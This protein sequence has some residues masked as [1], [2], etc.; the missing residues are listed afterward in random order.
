LISI[1]D[2]TDAELYAKAMDRLS[3]YSETT[4]GYVKAALANHEQAPFIQ[5]FYH[6]YRE[7]V[8]GKECQVWVDFGGKFYC[9]E[10]KVDFSDWKQSKLLTFDHSFKQKL[11]ER[12]AILYAN[13]QHETFEPMLKILKSAAKKHDDFNFVLRF[14]PAAEQRRAI[15]LSGY[16]VE[17]DVKNTEYKAVDDRKVTNEDDQDSI[18]SKETDAK[19]LLYEPEPSIQKLT[20]EQISEI[21]GRAITFASESEN[22]WDS[23]VQLTQ[24]FPKYAHLLLE[25]SVNSDISRESLEM[26]QLA[27]GEEQYLFMNGLNID[28]EDINVF[29]MLRMMR[30]DTK[31]IKE[32]ESVGFS[33]SEAIDLISSPMESKSDIEWGACFNVKTDLA[34]WL[35]D[36]EK[37]AMYAQ[38][39]S[40]L[41]TLMYPSHGNQF[42]FIR[43]NLFSALFVVDLTNPSVLMELPRLYQIIGQ[44]VPIRFGILPYIGVGESDGVSNLVAIAL[45]YI[46]KNVPGQLNSFL[47]QVSFVDVDGCRYRR[48]SSETRHYPSSI[49]KSNWKAT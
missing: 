22:K 49:S 42:K 35:N 37:D 38:F 10:F 13:I 23:L 11:T 18:T 30:T 8:E 34:I 46:Q 21:S 27:T 19:E 6:Y 25:K 24:N 44:R 17:L 43:K 12:T 16:G 14:I 36:I 47:T 20:K 3:D 1:G 32:L 4:I 41:E 26:M 40:G 7:N 33:S 29:G 48:R 9:D 2:E 5:Q 28:L 45:Y 31:V 39:P 15:Y